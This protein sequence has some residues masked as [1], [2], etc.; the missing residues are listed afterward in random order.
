MCCIGRTFEQSFLRLASCNFTQKKTF[1]SSLFD[2]GAGKNWGANYTS[3]ERA[4]T[5]P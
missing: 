5:L 2:I 3:S 4:E 1:P